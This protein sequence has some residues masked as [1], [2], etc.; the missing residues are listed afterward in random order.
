MLQTESVGGK[1]PN[2]NIYYMIKLNE[3]KLCLRNFLQKIG[4][5]ELMEFLCCNEL[6]L[7]QFSE[8]EGP[9]T[10]SGGVY[11]FLRINRVYKF[12][13]LIWNGK[14]KTAINFAV[15]EKEHLFRK[16]EKRLVPVKK[17]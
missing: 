14:M 8:Q 1:G 13:P 5:L 12:K 6:K 7:L 16:K 2:N 10:I 9:R 11:D 3:L 4:P 15:V 17:F